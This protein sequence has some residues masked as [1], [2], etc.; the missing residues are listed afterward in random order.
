MRKKDVI[1][2]ARSEAFGIFSDSECDFAFRRTLEYMNEKGAEIGECLNAARRIDTRDGESWIREWSELAER[3]ETQ[4]DLSLR[5]GH[6][7]SARE[8][9]LRACN[10]YRTAE[11]GTP[12]DDPRFDEL[13]QK[14]R[15]AFHK[16]C[17][18]F[19][20]EIMIVEVPFDG[21]MLPGYFWQPDNSGKKR[22]TLF[23]VG[24]NDSSGEEVFFANGFAAV[25]RGYNYFTFE[26]P[27]HRGAVH[28]NRGSIK[29]A[30][31]EV[32]F[33]AAFDVLASLPGVDER[34]ALTGFSFGGYVS[35]RVA[36]HEDRVAALI[37]NSPIINSYAVTMAFWAGIMKKIPLKWIAKLTEMK[38]KDKPVLK[39]FKDFTD[40][41]AGVYKTDMS[42]QEKFD[43]N[44]AFLRSMNIVADLEKITCPTL[45]LVSDGDGELLI[46]QAHQ[47]IAGIS[48]TRKDLYKFSL[49]EDGSD[50]HC[51][52]DNR[53]R[54]N[55]VT[56]DWLDE[57]FDH[58]S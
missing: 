47:F 41:T 52:L 30:D 35:S 39:A 18:L 48:S 12:P 31:Y 8:S 3:V 21:V 10:Y 29:R 5:M 45:A 11:Y 33:K 50:E 1:Q 20:P 27:G 46:E 4:G 22:P 17:P 7:I 54:S 19:F 24:G 32:P 6:P 56:L 51:Q 36:I 38:M 13:W 55:Q 44:I 37:P 23:S 9:Y 40:L 14:S 58:K 2:A 34:I 16:A 25:A 53:T 26:F 42:M 43:H 28:T 57:V 49:A 15:T